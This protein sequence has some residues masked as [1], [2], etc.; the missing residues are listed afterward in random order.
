MSYLESL[1]LCSKWHRGFW[2]EVQGGKE[3][4]LLRPQQTSLDGNE[5]QQRDMCGLIVD[6]SQD[7]TLC[8]C[9]SSAPGFDGPVPERCQRTL[10]SFW[11]TVLYPSSKGRYTC[12]FEGGPMEHS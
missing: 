11:A 3:Q 7:T 5:I 4:L 6:R 2:A 1:W 9:M 8:Q 12:W 10:D